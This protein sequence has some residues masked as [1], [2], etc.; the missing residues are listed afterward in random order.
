MNINDLIK[1]CTKI[2]DIK[3]QNEVLWSRSCILMVQK[4]TF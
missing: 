1:F 3:S 4:N 2:I